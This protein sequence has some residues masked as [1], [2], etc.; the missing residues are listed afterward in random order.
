MRN[1]GAVIAEQ[2]EAKDQVWFRF[3]FLIRLLHFL[4]AQHLPPRQLIELLPNTDGGVNV[5]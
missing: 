5:L 2:K 1:G 3:R 4:G